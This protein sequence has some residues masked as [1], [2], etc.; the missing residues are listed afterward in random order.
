MAKE[1]ASENPQA[2]E[3]NSESIPMNRDAFETVVVSTQDDLHK[4]TEH[5]ESGGKRYNFRNQENILR[6]LGQ[7]NEEGH[8][9]GGVPN[10][11]VLPRKT[12]M[13]GLDIRRQD[14]QFMDGETYLNRAIAFFG[15][16]EKGASMSQEASAKDKALLVLK[17]IAS[18]HPLDQFLREA[19][20]S[21]LHYPASLKW[22]RQYVDAGW[23][24]VPVARKNGRSS[25]GAKS[26]APS[27]QVQRESS[28]ADDSHVHASSDNN[29][30]HAS[31][32]GSG[33]T[34]LPEQNEAQ[35]NFVVVPKEVKRL[36]YD[37]SVHSVPAIQ[38]GSPSEIIEMQLVGRDQDGK[39]MHEPV[40]DSQFS[41]DGSEQES[42]PGHNE[43]QPNF[44]LLPREVRRLSFL[45]ESNSASTAADA[46]SALENATQPASSSIR[47]S[48]RISPMTTSS[49][50]AP[51]KLDD[52]LLDIAHAHPEGSIG[53]T[54]MRTMINRRRKLRDRFQ[55]VTN[56]AKSGAA[57]SENPKG[58]EAAKPAASEA[59]GKEKPAEASGKKDE[60]KKE[61][62]A[63][64]KK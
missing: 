9:S 43:S 21:G 38:R 25:P 47:T 54:L 62:K 36:T 19:K 32:E 29:S 5:G 52:H 14:G 57:A 48:A 6:D 1:K 42:F 10:L 64:A 4:L 37:P 12:N 15:I 22:L 41:A 59:S 31:A 63:D 7:F 56:P 44:V 11:S 35:P 30:S 45:P 8:K 53:G 18:G 60:A 23:I 16:Q 3:T 34:S 20:K 51:K 26:S 61:E 13:T 33:Q 17:F 55:S 39:E 50:F 46:L 28:E 49:I 27:I 2:I 58:G 24:D 40:T